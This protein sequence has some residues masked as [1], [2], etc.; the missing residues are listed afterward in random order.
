MLNKLNLQFFAEDK[1]LE[2]EDEIPFTDEED[3][4]EYEEEEEEIISEGEDDEEEYEPLD[5]KTKAI[6]K[7]KK[8][9]QELRRK[10]QEYEE[11]K[12][13][14]ELENENIRRVA[15]L[16]GKGHSEETAKAMAG[17]ELEQKKLRIKIASMEL[18][19]LEGNYP[20]ITSYASQIARDKESLPE[21]TYEQIYLAKY[22][23]QSEY[24]RKTQMEQ[25]ILHK[26]KKNKAGSLDQSTP[27]KKS[28]VK[29]SQADE[30][31]YQY[32]K[33]TKMKDL[34]RERFLELARED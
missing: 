6:I 2:L 26:S 11:K 13:A 1:D 29:L 17:K 33:K 32:L 7:H 10:L 3:P 24:D 4:I 15:E 31:V 5:K 18:A 25:E 14:D 28:A 22:Y 27:S 34:T 23:K 19:S 9:N 8:E 12:Q 30:R 20:G 16:Q 21:F